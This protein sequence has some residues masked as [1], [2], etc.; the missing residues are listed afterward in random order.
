MA[1]AFSRSMRSLDADS[2]SR[3]ALWI[4]LCAGLLL[5]AWIAWFVYSRVSRYEVTD[6]ARLEVDGAVSV[7]QAPIAGRIVSSAL[8]LDR[9]VAAG[10]TLLEIE[11]GPQ[12]LELRE[13]QARLASILPQIRSLDDE[14]AAHRKA[15]AAEREA[16]RAA[17]EQARAQLREAEAQ[18][19]LADDEA[20]RV[21]RMRAERLIAER[22]LVRARAEQRSRR[23]A[24]D[25]LESAVRK[26]E[27]QHETNDRDRDARIDE[28]R[29]A[30]ARLE[31]ERGVAA[32]TVERLA[33]E[34]QRRR[35]VAPV[36]GRLGEIAVLRPGGFVDEGDKVGA[37]VP[38]GRLRIVA[39]F[40]PP[41]A[42]GRIHAGQPARLRLQGFPWT[43]FGAIPARVSSVASE[44][45]N[46]RVRVELSVE[47]SNTAI[48]LQHGLPGSV[49][50][51]V[52]DVS[53]AAL[54]LRAAGQFVASPKSPFG[55]VRR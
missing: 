24:A 11:A 3:R 9:H 31:A 55:I 27:R 17:L 7:L 50:V 6:R 51:Q 20:G 46:G 49:E 5:A 45:R 22:D 28:L 43:Q 54:V 19:R 37:I 26:L 32:K 42:L 38:D 1:I 8:V 2:R 21:A 39:E 52:E 4:L 34:V 15:Q 47:S 13:A 12:R 35:I 36:S 29:A 53:P 16:G 40:E 44:V 30:I 14:I 33:Y 18:A 48:P 41:A 25:A 10:E 23:A